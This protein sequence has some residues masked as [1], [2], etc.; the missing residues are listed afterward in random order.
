MRSR[1]F[2]LSLVGAWMIGIGFRM[3]MESM[4][5]D[6][7]T[8]KASGFEFWYDWVFLMLFGV[9]V[10]VFMILDMYRNTKAEFEKV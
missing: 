9:F 4:N 6:Y 2:L 1:Y 10:F 3:M 5:N 7:V 8:T